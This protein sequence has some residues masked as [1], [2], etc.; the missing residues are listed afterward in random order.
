MGVIYETVTHVLETCYLSIEVEQ[1]LRD[2]SQNSHYDRDDFDA[3]VRLQLSAMAGQ[4][5]Q[6]SRE[7]LMRRLVQEAG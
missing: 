3:L 5:R 4:I 2:L 6:E 7:A 1:K